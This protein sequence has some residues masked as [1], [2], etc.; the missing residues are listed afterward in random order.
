MF[1]SRAI[2]LA[3]G[4]SVSAK[5]LDWVTEKRREG[6]SVFGVNN[7]YQCMPWLTD[8]VAYNRNWWEHYWPEDH[9]L[10]NGLFR[11]WTFHED[12][13][14]KWGLDYIEDRGQPPN[15]LS[16]DPSYI[17]RGHSS[18]Y[19]AMGVAYNA[20]HRNF[21]LLGFDMSYGKGYDSRKRRAGETPRHYFGEY[22]AAMQHWPQSFDGLIRQF[23]DINEEELGI[24]VYN[25]T[26]GTA[27]HH[28]EESTINDH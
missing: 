17:Y 22:P 24:K 5:Q 20:G 23:E 11:K 7:V 19:M 2:I 21:Y 18:S 1:A 3:T 26:P 12:L 9:L 13:A 28:F 10:R 4:P 16:T 14:L 15:G 25:L 8:L 27:L 6:W